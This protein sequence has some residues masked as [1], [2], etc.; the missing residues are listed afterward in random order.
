[1]RTLNHHSSGA[2]G[3]V[4]ALKRAVAI[5]KTVPSTLVGSGDDA[6]V[7]ALVDEVEVV[8]L[9]EDGDGIGI[10]EYSAAIVAEL[11]HSKQ[12]VFEGGHDL[13]FLDWERG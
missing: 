8:V 3:E 4:E 7:V 13:C 11:A 12:V 6:A 2:L 1:M 5:F 10:E 9:V